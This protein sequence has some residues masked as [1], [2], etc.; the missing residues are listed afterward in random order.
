MSGCL[1]QADINFTLPGPKSMKMPN[2][3]HRKWAE[4]LFKKL[5]NEVWSFDHW[6][7][8][9]DEKTGDVHCSASG[10]DTTRDEEAI[11]QEAANIIWK[12]VG[13]FVEVEVATCCLENLPTEGW[14]VDEDDY[15][16]WVKNNLL[17][18]MANEGKSDG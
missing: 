6:G 13:C 1:Y 7:Y 9:L 11:I 14:A 2:L 4:K 10:E 16:E 5:D 8:W 18:V 15:A 12:Y 3:K 17:D